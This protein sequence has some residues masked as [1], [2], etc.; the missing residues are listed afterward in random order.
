MPAG[1]ALVQIS[2]RAVV[3]IQ[4]KSG[5]TTARV[6]AFEV[7]TGHFARRRIQKAFIHVCKRSNFTAYTIV[8]RNGLIRGERNARL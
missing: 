7:L 1:R 6:A 4:Q 2:T 8:F 3:G 5:V